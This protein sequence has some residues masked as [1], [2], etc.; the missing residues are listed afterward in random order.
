MIISALLSRVRQIVHPFG[1]GRFK[2]LHGRL[3][4]WIWQSMIRPD[5]VQRGQTGI[6][7]N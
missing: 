2:W 5:P 3:A 4:R 6:A 7:A 1:K